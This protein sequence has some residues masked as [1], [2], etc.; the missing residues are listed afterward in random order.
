M[1]LILLLLAGLLVSG[2]L[3]EARKLPDGAYIKSAKIHILSGEM[4]RY[5]EAEY[6]LD[7]LFMNYGPH[8]EGLFL[9]NQMMVDI[10]EKT[11]S[12]EEK[13]KIVQRLVAYDDSLKMCCDN[14]DIKSKYRKG[15]E[16]F[17]TKADSTLVK[18]WRE[19]YN[20]GIGNLDL[21]KQTMIDLK[22]ITDSANIAFYEAKRDALIDTTIK[23]LEIAIQLD[24]SDF[25]TYVGIASVY[26]QQRKFDSANVWLAKGE[27]YFENPQDVKLQI[28]YNWINAGDYCAATV[29]L[30][31]YCNIVGNDTTNLV[32]L[33]VC[34]NSCGKYD[35]ALRTYNDVLA[36]DPQNFEALQAIGT[37][38][39][40][41]AR[42]ANDSATTYRDQE[43]SKMADHW[44]SERSRI[45]DSSLYYFGEAFAA[46]DTSLSAA[47]QFGMIAYVQGKYDKAVEAY[48]R[49]VQID[50]TLSDLWLSLGDTYI[51]LQQ[52]AN[53]IHP[54]EMVIAQEPDNKDIM[55]RLVDLYKENKQTTKAKEMQ[56]RLDKLQ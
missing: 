42:Y 20:I 54:Y 15:C 21:L 49:A 3:A 35:E 36:I 32:N 9:M 22:E 30:S 19:F 18:Y 39:N 10:L 7:S 38:F 1:K 6:M 33:G 51:Q 55:E 5:K 26:E 8:A 14:K 23:A 45:L 13:E 17:V 2:G 48:T 47:E 12:L 4:E 46:H 37:Y 50:S 52:F 34:Y 41:Q 31:E 11:P 27:P 53:A 25:R 24:S 16:D 56:A 40:Q 28:A 44:M 29:P 43:N